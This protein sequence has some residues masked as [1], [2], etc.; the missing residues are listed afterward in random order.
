M[1]NES[2]EFWRSYR[3]F[4]FTKADQVEGFG[5]ISPSNNFNI[6]SASTE[7]AQRLLSAM[8][9]AHRE[10]P[11]MILGSENIL[12]AVE[13]FADL[14]SR[15][16]VNWKYLV[17]RGPAAWAG[18]PVEGDY[19]FRQATVQDLNIVQDWYRAFNAELGES[20]PMP[21]E[22]T[23]QAKRHFVMISKTEG[24]FLAGRTNTM[25]FAERLWVGRFYV[26]P[27]QRRT[28]MGTIMTQRLL[29]LARKEGKMVYLLV[30]GKNEKAIGL[31]QNFGFE[32]VAV[33]AGVRFKDEQ[34]KGYD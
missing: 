28:G 11:K 7:G 13:E 31:N 9:S 1:M 19:V 16:R 33:N 26:R 4:S 18:S 14:K 15:D 5:G 2:D 10:L 30:N 23:I 22:L 8:L 32:T 17:M 3:F 27:E 6:Y 21:N 29:V 20:W 12:S 24:Q 25:N 34:S